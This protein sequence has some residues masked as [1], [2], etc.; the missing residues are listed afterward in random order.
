MALEAM[1]VVEAGISGA[2]GA[3]GVVRGMAVAGE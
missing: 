1:A 3:T 2:M